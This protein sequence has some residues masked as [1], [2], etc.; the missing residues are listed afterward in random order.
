MGIKYGMDMNGWSFVKAVAE[1]IMCELGKGNMI[2]RN[3]LIV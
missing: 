2:S 3:C 1:G